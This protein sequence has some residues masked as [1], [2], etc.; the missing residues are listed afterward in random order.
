MSQYAKV[1]IYKKEHKNKSFH[2]QRI[3][4]LYVEVSLPAH[5]FTAYNAIQ[6]HEEHF[7]FHISASLNHSEN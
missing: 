1:L 3:T 4:H 2:F 7:L 5:L 6:I